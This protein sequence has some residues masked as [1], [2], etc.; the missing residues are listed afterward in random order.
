MKI[1]QVYAL[2]S[3]YDDQEM[4]TFYEDVQAAMKL[5]KT[6][7]SFIIDDLMQRSGKSLGMTTLGNFG[8]DTQNDKGDMLVWFTEMN[9]LKTMNTCFDHKASKNWSW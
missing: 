7:Y 5:H 9:S 8:I 3:A 6:Q 2:T 4:K 1:I